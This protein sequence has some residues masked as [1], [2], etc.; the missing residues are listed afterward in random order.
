MKA[1]HN[2]TNNGHVVEK[3]DILEG[4]CYTFVIDCLLGFAG[5]VLAIEV[6]LAGSRLVNTGDHIKDRCLAGT[7]RSHKTVELLFLDFK[8]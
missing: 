4:S 7:V 6:K 1:D 8:V 2:V 3:T 5:K